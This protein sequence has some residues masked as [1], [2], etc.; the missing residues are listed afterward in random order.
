MMTEDQIRRLGA[1]SAQ[2]ELVPRGI[3]QLLVRSQQLYF[4]ITP[5][6]S[7]TMTMD[8]VNEGSRWLDNLRFDAD[9]PLNWKKTIEPNTIDRLDPTLER[10]ISL[11]FTPPS[12]VGV[13]KYD[14]RVRATSRSDNLP[15]EAEPRTVTIQV[16]AQANVFSTAIIVLVILGLVAGIVV[17]GIRLTKR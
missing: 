16:E 13:G 11:T 2:L 4:E 3:G 10:R 1:G 15:I 5:G 8:V 12:D 7:V 9:I 6:Q 17:F 14:I